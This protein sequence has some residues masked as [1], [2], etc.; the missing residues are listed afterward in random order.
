MPEKRPRIL[1][2]LNHKTL[3]SFE[4]STLMQLGYEVLV[5]K[6]IPKFGFRSATVS[7]EYDH[8]LS[9]PTDD[10]ERLNAFNFYEGEWTPEIE[11]LVNRHF[12]CVFVMPFS[13]QVTEAVAKFD[14]QIVLR[15]FGLDNRQTYHRVLSE[16]YGAGIVDRLKRL[17]HRFWFGEGYKELHEVENDWLK[18]RAIYLPLGLPEAFFLHR[19]SWRGGNPR[20]LFVSPNAV[21]DPYYAAVYSNFKRDFGDIAHTIVGEQDVPVND[22]NMLGFVPADDLNK[23][24]QECS[25]LYY[26]SV[27]ARHV[28]YSPIE[29]AIVGL[30]VV[31]YKGS[32]FDRLCPESTMGAASS[33]VEARSFLNR[34]LGGDRDFIDAVRL[35]QR[36]I[37]DMY[38][39]SALLRV[40]RD[41]LENTGL[42]KAIEDSSRRGTTAR[43]ILT[44]VPVPLR[45]R[46]AGNETH[47]VPM[48]S[49]A[50]A[51]ATLG[52]SLY[53]GADF[54]EG[55]FPEF[56]YSITGISVAESFGRWSDGE[57]TTILLRHLLD[58]E[59][60][61]DLSAFGYGRNA[62]AIV[63]IK[64]GNVSR[65]VSFGAD[66]TNLAP[67]RMHFRLRRPTNRIEIRVPH[68]MRPPNDNRKVGLGFVR[69][70]AHLI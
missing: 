40:W 68:P 63:R 20:V 13:K 56:V 32:L 27:E 52:S 8:S 14:G 5:P 4:V 39:R 19:Q 7:F 12:A 31:Y 37:A 23:L 60:Y 65:S 51:K 64:I 36:K 11:R 69:L 9:L 22:P 53:D 47:F 54:S 46:W 62:G 61:L 29:A 57:K 34:L 42:D 6:I 17:G 1:W 49:P 55:D 58:K 66:P 48:A 18:K 2:L 35:D 10:L 21:S 43:S 28:H 25:A 3:M 67:A 45:R 15:A 44:F 33:V 30:P 50:V 16:M 38:D 26:H 24:L 41:S 70:Q 59:F